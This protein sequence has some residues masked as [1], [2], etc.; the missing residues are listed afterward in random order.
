M[1]EIMV[2]FY[3]YCGMPLVHGI[4]DCTHISIKKSA[5]FPENY[6]YYKKGT[7]NMVVEA[8]LDHSKRFTNLYIGLPVIK[9]LF[10]SRLFIEMLYKGD[11]Y[12]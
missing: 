6:Y 9:E 1:H 2:E 3:N 12:I 8:V 4:I 5:C 7:Y 10:E 11:Y